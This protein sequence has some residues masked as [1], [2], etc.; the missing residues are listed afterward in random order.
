MNYQ[1]TCSLIFLCFAFNIFGMEHEMSKDSKL[2]DI[3]HLVVLPGT[4]KV[5]DKDKEYIHGIFPQFEQVHWSKSPEWPPD[6]GQEQCLACLKETMDP[7]IEEKDINRI[8]LHGSSMGT[9]TA[10]NYVAEN[11][12]K[13]KMV[14]LEGIIASGNS[15]IS[16]AVEM[17]SPMLIKIPLSYYWLPY[18]AKV[19]MGLFTPTEKGFEFNWGKKFQICPYWPTGKQPFLSV[20][21]IPQDLPIVLLHSI[22]DG[23]PLE[24]AKA[25]YEGLKSKGHNDVYLIPIIEKGHDHLLNPK[26]NQKEI[27]ALHKILQ[28]HNLLPDQDSSMNQNGDLSIYQPKLDSLAYNTLSNKEWHFVLVKPFCCVFMLAV[29]A[30]LF[31]S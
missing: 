25:I 30:Y 4:G 16:L 12:D 26:K 31:G 19:A 27:A 6:L 11:A 17:I 22:Y 8:I 13:V 24:Q 9:A 28:K 14:I 7:L 29:I 23:L 1:I 2:D 20:E 21:K 18:F 10:L 15:P 3:V 5:G